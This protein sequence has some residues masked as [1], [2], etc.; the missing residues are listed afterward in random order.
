MTDTKKEPTC[1]NEIPMW[2]F[3]KDGTRTPSELIF[4]EEGNYCKVREVQEM[5]IRQIIEEESIMSCSTY[6]TEQLKY[7]FNITEDMIEEYRVRVK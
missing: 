5:V 7:F 6:H 2:L 4:N 3:H 1:L